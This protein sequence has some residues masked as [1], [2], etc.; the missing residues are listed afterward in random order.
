MAQ[1]NE[2]LLVGGTVDQME[3]AILFKLHIRQGRDASNEVS[4][5]SRKLMHF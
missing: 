2:R 5:G 3:T 4:S 1:Y